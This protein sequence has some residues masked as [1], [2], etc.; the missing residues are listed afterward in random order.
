[1]EQ[2]SLLLGIGQVDS[3]FG[4][5]VRASSATYNPFKSGI[6]QR[7]SGEAR[8]FYRVGPERHER[9]IWIL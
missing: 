5:L 7:S 6:V 8:T 3:D 1:M 4:T 9:S 2:P